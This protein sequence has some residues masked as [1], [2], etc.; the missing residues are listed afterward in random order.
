MRT[1]ER[2]KLTERCVDMSVLKVRVDL[3]IEE[4]SAEV[5]AKNIAR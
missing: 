3:I 5:V 1:R 4:L 2:V